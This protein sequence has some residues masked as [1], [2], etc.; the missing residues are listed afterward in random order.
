MARK[1]PKWS[2]S[3]LADY[4]AWTESNIPDPKEREYEFKNFS[5]WLASCASEDP[6]HL[7]M[8]ADA[9]KRRIKGAE[10]VKDAVYIASR[11]FYLEAAESRLQILTS[12]TDH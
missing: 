5:S 4:V 8:L 1:S 12:S 7:T 6:S 11:K 3:R 10:E 2:K 9:I